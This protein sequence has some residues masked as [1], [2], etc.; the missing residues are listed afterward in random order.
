[1]VADAARLEV[2]VSTLDC[3]TRIIDCGVTARGSIEAGIRLA[4]I[5]MAGI[6]HAE[7]CRA[8]PEA[9]DGAGVRA[10]CAENPI[11]ACMA[12]QYAGWAVQGEKFFAMGSGP[13]RAAAC[14]EELF[15]DIGLC[16]QPDRCVGVLE[17][18]NL[19]PEPVCVDIAAKCNIVPEHLTLLVA[20]TSSAAGTIQIVA[21]SVETALHK[22]HVLKFDLGAVKS[23]WGIAPLPPHGDEEMVALGRTNDAI[24]YGT[25]VDLVV[26]TDDRV[27]QEIGPRV[28]SNSSSDYGRPFEEIFKRYDHDFYRIDPMLFSPAQIT[29]LNR[30]SGRSFRYGRFAS[31]VLAESFRAKK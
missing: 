2:I 10:E 30:A 26:E 27:L 21:R 14:R 5:C 23:G 3:G 25:S 17:T 8:E 19:P 15:E 20:R 6:G 22:L 12:S 13:M 16:E 7:M 28:P 11:A 24:L 9:W 29:F 4:D 1:M 31:D 18:S